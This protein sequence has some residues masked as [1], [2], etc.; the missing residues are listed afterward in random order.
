MIYAH[1]DEVVNVRDQNHDSH[2]FLISVYV[3]VNP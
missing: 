1:G 3:Y 2:A